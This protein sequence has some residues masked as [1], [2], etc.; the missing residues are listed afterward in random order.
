MDTKIEELLPSIVPLTADVQLLS[1]ATA[2]G[3][4][5]NARTMKTGLGQ[6]DVG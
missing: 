3:I 6:S 5:Y 2:E 1:F 4:D